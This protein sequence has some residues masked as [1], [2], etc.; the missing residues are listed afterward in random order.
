MAQP[1]V[2]PLIFM[3]VWARMVGRGMNDMELCQPFARRPAECS[4]RQ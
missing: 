3:L 1:I 2:W 4:L